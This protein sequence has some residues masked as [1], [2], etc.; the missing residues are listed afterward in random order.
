M[1][2]ASLKINVDVNAYLIPRLHK[3]KKG[4]NASKTN[5]ISY[6]TIYENSKE[7]SAMENKEN[8]NW[9]LHSL[10]AS[11]ASVAAQQGISDRLI[12]KQGRWSSETARNGY[13]QDS[14]ESRLQVSRSLGV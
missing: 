4:H 2:K 14:V 13:I 9:G 11:E 12:S 7:L 6:T 5:G 10:R 3:T 8:K 1:S